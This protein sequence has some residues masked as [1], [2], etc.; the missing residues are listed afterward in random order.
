MGFFCGF[1]QSDNEPEHEEALQVRADAVVDVEL[2][3]GEHD[4]AKRTID[5]LISGN[6]IRSPDSTQ[7][8]WPLLSDLSSNVELPNYTQALYEARELAVQRMQAEARELEATGI[9][10]GSLNEKSHGWGS[11]VTEFFAIGTAIVPTDGKRT[12]EPPIPV[13][14]LNDR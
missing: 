12:I 8:K 14:D 3:R 13:L 9:V 4:L 10:G 5:Y 1:G 11:H 6:A 2:R 7:T